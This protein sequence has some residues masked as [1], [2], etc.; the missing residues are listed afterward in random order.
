MLQCRCLDDRDNT[1]PVQRH[2]GYISLV[3]FITWGVS[4]G[5]QSLRLRGCAT[6]QSL[7]HRRAAGAPAGRTHGIAGAWTMDMRGA[8]ARG[9]MATAAMMTGK[10]TDAT[11]PAGLH[12]PHA[13]MCILGRPQEPMQ[14]DL[15]LWLEAAHCFHIMVARRGYCE[16]RHGRHK[17]DREV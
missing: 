11:P 6:Q 9:T 1:N 13:F 7:L 10:R 3:S 17:A 16:L 15:S 5:P 14:Q 4:A 12:L 8:P 2:N